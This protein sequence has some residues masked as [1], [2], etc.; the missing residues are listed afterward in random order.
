[1]L[2]PLVRTSLLAALCAAGAAHA[3]T[4]YVPAPGLGS[5]GGSAYEVQVSVSN[6]AAA[7]GT[8]KQAL[9]ATNTDGTQRSTP[10]T[11]VTVAGGHTAVV[12]AG[13]AFSGL[14]ELAGGDGLRYSARLVGSGP[15]KLGVYLPVITSDNVIHGGQTAAVQ[16]L[17]SGSGR[18]ADLTMIN[19]A[20]VANQCTGSL[21]GADGSLVAGP[22]TFNLK[23]LSTLA[24]TDLFAGGAASEV[25]LTMSCTQSFFTYVLLSD[26]ATG[27]VTYLGPAGNGASGIGSTPSACPTG[28]ICFDAKGI[29]HQPTPT[30]RVQRVQFPAP[31]GVAT[32]LRLTLDVTVGPWWA[33][34]PAGKTLIYWF[35]INRNFDMAGLLYFRGPD[36]AHPALEQSQAIARHGIELTHP[37]KLKIVQPFTAIV[38]HT[39]HCD[40][41]YDMGRGVYTVTITD[42]S[43]GQVVQLVGAPNV[44]S[45]TLKAS[46][47]LITDMGFTGTNVDEVPTDGWTYSNLH[48]EVYKQ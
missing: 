42:T 16:G 41:D 27:E 26:A 29:V 25:R 40:N 35:V 36:P 5:I 23:P 21:Y 10:A 6:T 3:G 7:S 33:P 47:L 31:A 46:D 13:P 11:T 14:I 39:Y 34:D 15:G 19:L 18:T 38:G 37:Q 8:V 32:R 24:L 4:V 44:H 1:M 17:A 48:V 2:R 12:K 28:A 22:A 45:W 43:T 9:L 30:H 20:S